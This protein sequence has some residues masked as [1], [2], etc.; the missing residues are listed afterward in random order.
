MG[1]TELFG[2]V[3]EAVEAI[4]FVPEVGARGKGGVG[5]RT[6]ALIEVEGDVSV[7]DE[8]E[9][10]GGGAAMLGASLA[11]EHTVEEVVR[12]MWSHGGLHVGMM[13]KCLA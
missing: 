12:S 13:W 7:E 2:R 6:A 5:V 9:G 11:E 8:E 3:F 1:R 4:R 10:G